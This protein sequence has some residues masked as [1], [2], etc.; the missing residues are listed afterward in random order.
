MAKTSEKDAKNWGYSILPI[1]F[2]MSIGEVYVLSVN[3]HIKSITSLGAPFPCA[4]F[5]KFCLAVG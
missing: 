4:L 5:T 2:V 3:L 1:S